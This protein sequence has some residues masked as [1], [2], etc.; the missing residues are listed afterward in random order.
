MLASL[1]RTNRPRGQGCHP[2]EPCTSGFLSL[3]LAFFR[4]SWLS[5]DEALGWVRGCWRRNSTSRS[6]PAARKPAI[7]RLRRY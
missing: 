5:L 7:T 6:F 2:A 4:H 1:G 3:S